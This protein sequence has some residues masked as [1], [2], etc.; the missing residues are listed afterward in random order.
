L[1]LPVVVVALALPV[2]LVVTL[3]LSARH[4]YVTPVR[5]GFTHT[6]GGN[7]DVAQ[8]S[9]GTIV[10]RMSGITVAGGHPC[11]AF[12]ATMNFD[13]EPCFEVVDLQRR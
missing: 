5:Q 6:G 7:I 13:L 9:P 10:V 11:K 1:L 12:K 3:S 8:P 4:G 2:S